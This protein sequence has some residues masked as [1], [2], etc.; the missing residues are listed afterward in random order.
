MMFIDLFAGKLK[1]RIDEWNLAR[2]EAD[3]VNRM[4]CTVTVTLN[5]D[6]AIPKLVYGLIGVP[7]QYGC[8]YHI[9]L[10]HKFRHAAISL[11]E[12]RVGSVSWKVKRGRHGKRS[13]VK[14]CTIHGP[15]FI[16]DIRDPGFTESNVDYMIGLLIPWL[17]EWAKNLTHTDTSLWPKTLPFDHAE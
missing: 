4:M 1:T 11:Y 9:E 3:P 14:A 16:F 6:L 15:V 2:Y 7:Y 10:R 8:P 17:D 12:D 13:I 5:K